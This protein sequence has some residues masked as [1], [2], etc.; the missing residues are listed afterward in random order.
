M[1]RP[2]LF[3]CLALLVSPLA[4]T[5]CWKEA[6]DIYRLDPWLLYSIAKKES[7]MRVS[8]VNTNKD[9]SQDLGLMQINS[10]H[11]DKLAKYG[12]TREKLLTDP[13]INIKVGA[14]ILSWNVHRHGYNKFSLGA[15]NAGTRQNETQERRRDAYANSVL[16]IYWQETSKFRQ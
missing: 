4:N 2:A 8:V 5:N 13:C 11:L 3:L 12:I 1:S 15:Y 14:W 7:G 6:G 9:G 16:G 10:I